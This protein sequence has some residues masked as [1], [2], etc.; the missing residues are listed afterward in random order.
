MKSISMAVAV[1]VCVAVSASVMPVVGSQTNQGAAP[2]TNEMILAELRG[3]RADLAQTS[4]AAVRAQLLVARVQMQEQRIHSLGTQLEGVRAR[5][6]ANRN[7]QLPHESQ[8]E[9]LQH[10]LDFPDSPQERAPE[11]QRDLKAMV[12]EHQR[13]LANFRAAQ[14]QITAEE[15]ELSNQLLDEQNRWTDRRQLLLPVGDN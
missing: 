1:L 7:Q 9:R 4:G 12:A 14:Q 10:S 11:I 15:A 13:N 6:T 3:L 5:L 8:I 2:S